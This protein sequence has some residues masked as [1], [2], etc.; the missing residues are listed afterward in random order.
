[1]STSSEERSHW[2]ERAATTRALAEKTRDPGMREDLFA[3]AATCECLADLAGHRAPA[4]ADEQ[5]PAAC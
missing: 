2:R 3:I 1:M 5:P 4:Q